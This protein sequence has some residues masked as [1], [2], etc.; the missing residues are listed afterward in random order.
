MTSSK[1]ETYS[2]SL[3]NRD[4][5]YLGLNPENFK[6]LRDSLEKSQDI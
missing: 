4:K 1:V 3:L 5:S 2:L 6:I